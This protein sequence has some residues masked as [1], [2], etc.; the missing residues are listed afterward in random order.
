[1]SGLNCSLAT[2]DGGGA[3]VRD[4]L[5]CSPEAGAVACGMNLSWI[6]LANAS[7]QDL[8]DMCL[9]EAEYLAKYLG[10][11][12][13]PVFLPVFLV[14]LAIF[15]VGALGN[16]LTCAVILRY[17]VIVGK[18]YRSIDSEKRVGNVDDGNGHYISRPYG[19]SGV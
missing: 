7:A 9:S 19:V 1:M 10:P 16:A 11:P 13:S 14:F 4:D 15:V 18:C 17:K 2:S 5:G 3:V 6:F 12:R 8:D